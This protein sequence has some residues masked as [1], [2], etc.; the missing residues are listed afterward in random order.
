MNYYTEYS[1]HLL[2]KEVGA[3]VTAYVEDGS[4]SFEKEQFPSVLQKGL[5]HS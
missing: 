3:N 1:I 4:I 2:P 5:T